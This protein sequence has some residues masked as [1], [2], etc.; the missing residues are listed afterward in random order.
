MLLNSALLLAFMVTLALLVFPIRVAKAEASAKSRPIPVRSTSN[1]QGPTIAITGE[2]AEETGN[3]I[4]HFMY[5]VPT[6]SPVLVENQI[7]ENNTQ[8]VR[9]LS[10]EL[11]R[12]G[13]TFTL[14][15]EFQIVGSGYYRNKFDAT[16]VIEENFENGKGKKPLTNLLDYIKLDGEGYGN[17]L[18]EGERKN[19][20]DIVNRVR[21]RFN[22]RGHK[23]P[24][25]ISVYSVKPVNGDYDYESKYDVV[26]ARIN[27]LTF[28][29]GPGVPKMAIKLD[30]IGDKVES[31]NLWGSIRGFIANLLINPIDIDKDGNQSLLEFACSIL[32][33]DPTYTFPVAKNLKSSN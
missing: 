18:I 33:Q 13:K 10:Y 15:S 16:D 31:N 7:S 17:F 9:F 4:D 32:R 19:G 28:Q 14:V 3:P 23:S 6:I 29:R 11:K 25:T 24:I 1:D 22:G 5:F 20:R 30:S 12:E 27:T 2:F 26:V 8:R 21:A